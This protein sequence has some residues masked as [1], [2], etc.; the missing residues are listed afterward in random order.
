MERDVTQTKESAT[1][2]DRRSQKDQ[3]IFFFKIVLSWLPWE[4]GVPWVLWPLV[5]FFY[6]VFFE[7]QKKFSIF[8]TISECF[9]PNLWIVDTLVQSQ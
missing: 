3:Q 5:Y 4:P 7:L 1:E 9:M 8:L 6:L 2:V